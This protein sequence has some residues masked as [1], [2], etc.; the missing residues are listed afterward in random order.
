MFF[1]LTIINDSIL[2]LLFSQR[3]LSTQMK[4]IV[5]LVRKID[6]SIGQMPLSNSLTYNFKKKC[7]TGCWH[8]K[9]LALVA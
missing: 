4:M 5:V 9:L 1:I 2:F 8:Q 6:R 7:A 3:E